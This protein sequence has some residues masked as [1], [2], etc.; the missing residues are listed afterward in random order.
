[1]KR[2]LSFLMAFCLLISLSACKSSKSDDDILKFFKALDYTLDAKSAAI[3]GSINTVS[4]DKNSTMNIDAQFNQENQIQCAVKVGLE[5]DGNKIDDYLDFYIKD[6]K[7]YLKN[8]STTS[9]SV[10]SNIGIK[11]NTK[12]SAYNPFLNY[13]DDE[14]CEMFTS[15][16]KKGD[17]YTFDVDTDKMAEVL[18][19]YGSVSLSEAKVTATFKEKVISY[20][21]IEAKGESSITKKSKTMEFKIELNINDYNQLKEIIYPD[22]LDSYPTST[23]SSDTSTS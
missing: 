3:S 16:S 11:D 18:D 20:L 6:G 19:N 1:M 7:T 9:Q 22:D 13:S 8:M 17:T 5:A 10:A 12:F 23:D 21:C 15:S 4:G 14:L 2:F